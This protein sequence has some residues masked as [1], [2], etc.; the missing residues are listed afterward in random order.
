MWREMHFD[1]FDSY[2]YRKC[3][4]RLIAFRYMAWMSFTFPP[5]SLALFIC[6]VIYC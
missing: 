5:L 4:N 2:E 1:R 6:A 3:I